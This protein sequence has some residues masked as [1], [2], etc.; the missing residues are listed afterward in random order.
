MKD[1]LQ[2]IEE[3]HAR[4]VATGNGWAQVLARKA[5]HELVPGEPS[6]EGAPVEQQER[7]QEWL[8]RVDQE[9]LHQRWGGHASRVTVLELDAGF[10]RVRDE[11]GQT[12]WVL[13]TDLQPLVRQ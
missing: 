10:T 4:A 6:R 3:Y 12:R 8:P 1:S 7:L 9:V 11:E 2:V 13:T 5:C